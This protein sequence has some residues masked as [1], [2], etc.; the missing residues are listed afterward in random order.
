MSRCKPCSSAVKGP[1]SQSGKVSLGLIARPGKDQGA[2]SPHMEYKKSPIQKQA[3]KRN[4]DSEF[5]HSDL[6]IFL[7]ITFE[8]CFF[9]FFSGFFGCL[10]LLVTS[11]VHDIL[12]AGKSGFWWCVG[13]RVSTY[14]LH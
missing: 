9:F 13:V 14:G 6:F 4:E 3:K 2:S 10:A 1:R 7:N 11:A 8:M 5:P 12:C